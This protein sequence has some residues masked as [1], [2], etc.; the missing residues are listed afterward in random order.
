MPFP[1]LDTEVRLKMDYEG[2]HGSAWYEAE[3]YRSVSQAAGRLLRHQADYGCLLL[4]D[5]RFAGENP[6]PQLS[7]WLR[8][9]LR[10]QRCKADVTLSALQSHAEELAEFF[11]R[12]EASDVPPAERVRGLLQA[13]K[14]LRLSLVILFWGPGELL[15]IA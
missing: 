9:E 13:Y 15:S 2:R 1:S 7:S 5:G 3:A 6:P 8:Q 14:K 10:Q 12:N 4:L 11:L